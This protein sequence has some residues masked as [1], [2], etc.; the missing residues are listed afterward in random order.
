MKRTIILE[1]PKLKNEK[2]HAP[3]NISADKLHKVAVS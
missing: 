2:K 1:P 3:K